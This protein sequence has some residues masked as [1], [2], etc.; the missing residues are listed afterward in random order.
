MCTRIVVDIFVFLVPTNDG[1]TFNS[2]V[3]GEVGI[4]FIGELVKF[5]AGKS[6]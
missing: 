4:A 2:I 3:L 1:I 5:S 6:L